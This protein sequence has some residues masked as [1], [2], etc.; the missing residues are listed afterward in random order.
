M[1]DEIEYT[2]YETGKKRLQ[3]V[4]AYFKQETRATTQANAVN[5]SID[6]IEKQISKTNTVVPNLK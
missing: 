2:D 1:S 4:L 6:K 3:D 5:S